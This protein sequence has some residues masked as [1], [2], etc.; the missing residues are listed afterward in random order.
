MWFRSQ[1][2][3][4]GFLHIRGLYDPGYVRW[5]ESLLPTDP[6]RAVRNLMDNHTTLFVARD[7]VGEVLQE[8]GE[9]QHNLN[10]D[11]DKLYTAWHKDY[12]FMGWPNV[13]RFAMYF[14]DYKDTQWGSIGFDNTIKLV[15][16]KPSPGDLVVWNLSTSHQAR[17]SGL[18]PRNAIFF[19]YG[20]GKELD[21]Y[22]EW[23]KGKKK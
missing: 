17:V 8:T 20:N 4:D 15:S 23:R 19:D 2:N 13:W 16:V 14:R 21:K 7:I 12:P 10:P 11:V 18:T 22:V 1:A 9:N 3:Q 5:L 6:H